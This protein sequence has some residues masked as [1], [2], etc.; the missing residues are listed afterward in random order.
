MPRNTN[1]SPNGW[2]G[3]ASGPQVEGLTDAALDRAHAFY[4]TVKSIPGALMAAGLRGSDFITGWKRREDPLDIGFV[5]ESSMLDER[6]LA[7]LKEIFPV[8]ILFGDPAQ[9]AP[10]GQSGEMVFDKLPEPRKL[11]AGPDPPAG[12][13]QPDPR[14]RPCAGR[15]QP[16]LRGLRGDDPRRRRAATTASSWPSGSKAT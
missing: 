7:D 9:L 4:Q 12:G 13:R 11:I 14:S 1:G 6:Q 3:R 10:V 8:L 16:E 2:P 15:R 5:D